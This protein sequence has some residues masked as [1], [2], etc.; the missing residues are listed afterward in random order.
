MIADIPAKARTQHLRRLLSLQLRGGRP[1]KETER[2][3]TALAGTTGMPLRPQN[4]P[5]VLVPQ[6]FQIGSW[7]FGGTCYFHVQG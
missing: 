4:Q 1:C 6:G 5:H 7:D 2:S 3:H